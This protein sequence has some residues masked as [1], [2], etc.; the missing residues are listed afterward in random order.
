MD[1]SFSS[2]I[3]IS[4]LELTFCGGGS[5]GGLHDGFWKG[6]FCEDFFLLLL[7]IFAGRTKEHQI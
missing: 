6:V 5:G 1:F 2:K 3:E 7:G 4:E